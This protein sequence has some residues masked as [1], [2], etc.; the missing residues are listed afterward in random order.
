MLTKVYNV[1]PQA[2]VTG[3]LNPLG[4]YNN[5]TA[6]VKGDNVSYN[7]SSYVAT[8]S[9]TGNLPT[10][11]SKWQV[12]A[13]KGATGSTGATGATGSTGSA[14]AAGVVQS[15]NGISQA[16]VTLDTSNIADSADKR[17]CTDAQKTVIGNTSGTNSG[18]NATNSQYSGLAASKQDALVSATNIKTIN[19]TTLLGSGDIAITP[20]TFDATSPST[21]AF[22]D[23]A[24]VGAATTAARRDHK[25]A[26]MAAPTSV[27]GNAGTVTN[28]TLTTALT[29]NTGTVTL[30]GNVANTSALTLGAGASSV[31]GAN[32]GDQTTL[33]ISA[34]P[35]TQTAQGVIVSMTYGES[36]TLGDLLYFKS[37][38]KVY[39]ADATSIATAKLPCM[40]L[41]LA[42]AA[43]GANNVLLMGTYKDSTKWTGG[44]VLTVGGMCY[45]STG[46]ATTQT[47]PATSG[48]VIQVVGVA[49]AAD[50]IM[51][52]PVLTYI[53]HV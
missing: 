10:D 46:G 50:V 38:G 2:I 26:M 29:V 17:Y 42:T 21:Q 6:Y 32:T 15:V 43:S 5:G 27:T 9:T 35:T 44:T 7:G 23:A 24:A 20:L 11:T 14:G 39:K 45:M 3:G 34:A 51:F 18:D 8:T 36:I 53:T 22:G 16:A 49:I 52:N 13:N 33:P 1:N 12:V 28:A 41:A 30:T 31:S 40:G 47:Q 48:N 37:D 25:H 4:A 19:S